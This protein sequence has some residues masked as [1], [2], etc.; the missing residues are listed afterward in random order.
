MHPTIRPERPADIAAIARLTEAAFRDAAHTSHTEAF[1]VDALRRAGQLTLSLVA[2]EDGRL[3]GHVAI[4][5]VAISSGAKNWFGLGP[6]S[7]AP[8]RQGRGIGTRLMNAALENLRGQHAAGCVVLGDPA[9]YGRFGFA[10][11]PDM[12]LPGVP[13]DYFQVLAFGAAVPDGD[14]SYHEAFNATE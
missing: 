7:V 2:E 4:S 8:D 3:V 6:I 12:R 13:P 9:F 10:V 1:I 5:P 14:V 11:Q